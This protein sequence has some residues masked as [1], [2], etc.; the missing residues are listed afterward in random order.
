MLDQIWII[1]RNGQGLKAEDWKTSRWIS[2]AAR[3]VD[4]GKAEVRGEILQE[5]RLE[6]TRF[7][8]ARLVE[9]HNGR[10]CKE[11]ES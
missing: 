7:K 10:S 5:S 1:D 4:A 3:G 8:E 2:V 6:E 9:G 11:C